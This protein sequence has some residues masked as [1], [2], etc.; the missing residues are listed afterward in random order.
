MSVIGTKRTS[1]QTL[2]MSAYR[3]K[4]DIPSSLANVRK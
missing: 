4:A 1:M 2:I 3:G